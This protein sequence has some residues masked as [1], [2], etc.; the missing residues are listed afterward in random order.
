MN[1][2]PQSNSYMIPLSI[3]I[4]GLII[5]GAVIYIKNPRAGTSS[6]V[7]QVTD[8]ETPNA[9][10]EGNGN[11]VVDV[12][13]DDDPMVG[14]P[15]APVTI[16][17]FSD[18]QCSFCARFHEQT[19]SELMQKYIDTGKVRFVYRDFPLDSLH[20]DA[21]RAAEASQCAFE[22]GK[23]WEYH[24]I[25]F[26]NQADIGEDKLKAY[27]VQIGLSA[28][29]FNSCLEDGKY[30]EEVSKDFMDGQAAGV[31]GTP[32]FFVNG[33]QIVG[34]LPI[35]SFETMIEEALSAGGGS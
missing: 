18:F 34:A 2:S 30:S 33:K 11:E 16:I 17:E 7:E 14:D 35:A 13:V 9:G 22:Q 21:A 3:I 28:D 20:P 8:K 24:D 32:S 10:D 5:G 31:T 19:F 23:Y 6:V 15:N 26:K 4:A 27:A 1:D 12:S 29:Q 25:L